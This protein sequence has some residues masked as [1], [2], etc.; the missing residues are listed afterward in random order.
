MKVTLND[1]CN[2]INGG[3]WSDK[4]YTTSGI[5][6][7]KVSNLQNDGVN[8]NNID[9]LPESSIQRY[10]RH[11]LQKGDLV[12]AT[13]GSHPNLVNSAAGRAS[14]ISETA[15]GY[16]LNQNAVCVRSRDIEVLD[17]FYLAY[18]G[19]TS[20]FQNYIQQRG[21]GAANQMRIAIG[22]IKEF[23]INLPQLEVQR[24]IASILSAYDDLIENNLKRIKLLEELAQRT[25]E[26][27]FI[28]FRVN[29]EALAIDEETG[30]PVGWVQ[31]TLE[32]LVSFQNGFA[33][34]SSKFIEVGQP[35]IK[36]RN[37]DNNTVDV[38]NADCVDEQYAK[39]ADKFKLTTGDLLIAMT[40]A[41]VGKVG[42]FPYS[43]KDCYLN[44]R[45]GRFIKKGIPNI[46]FAFS[47]MTLGNGLQQV[48]N[49][50]SGAA[51]PNISG[52]Q[53]LSIE[54]A[55]PTE[56]LLVSFN[57]LA[58]ANNKQVLNLQNQNRL[59]K[60]SRDILLPRLMNGTI[61]VQEAER[62]FAMAA[63][64]TNEYIVNK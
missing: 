41:T 60:H 11:L 7:I 50:A 15:M 28:K 47:L 34:K 63:E 49:Y 26:E 44:Q 59:L 27:W 62:S 56:N 4:E 37:I 22:A 3:A 10:S 24:R 16:L 32:D 20:Q 42:Y 45:V 19:K 55:I 17:Q 29:G 14:I 52:S 57:N 5:P 40:G 53:I 36:I 2:F 61:S 31:G 58:E 35:I 13:V 39:L 8:F 46:H 43:E 25:Y 21:R 12:I 30:L 48:L 38:L 6:V 1:V 9:F 64:P 23:E 18:L 51:Q 54:T 33:F